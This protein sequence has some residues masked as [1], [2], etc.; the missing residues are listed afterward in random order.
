LYENDVFGY[1]TV[2]LVSFQDPNNPKNHPLFWMT[3]LKCYL[4]CY[5]SSFFVFDFLSKGK[6]DKTTG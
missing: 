3:D 1:I 6:I 4:D 5:S 2:E